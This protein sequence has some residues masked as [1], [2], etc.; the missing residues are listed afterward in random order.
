MPSQMLRHLLEIRCVLMAV[1][2]YRMLHGNFDEL[3]TIGGY[4]NRAFAVRRYL[5]AIYIFPGHGCCLVWLSRA[6]MLRAQA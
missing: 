4:R 1:N 6:P 2:L 5:P 3:F